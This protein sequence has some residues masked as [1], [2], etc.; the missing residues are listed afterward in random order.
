MTENTKTGN[1]LLD[2]ANVILN[3]EDI[4]LISE[5]LNC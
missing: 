2:A 3:E 1:Q 4:E 5:F